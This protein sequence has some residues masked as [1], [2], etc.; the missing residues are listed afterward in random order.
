MATTSRLSDRRLLSRVAAAMIMFTAAGV[1]AHGQ[2]SRSAVVAK[3]LTQV[4]EA[5]KLE[6]IA[7][8][9]P[10]VPGTFIAALYIQGTQLLVV[11]AKYSAPLLLVD[12]IGKKDYRDVYIDLSSASVAGTK[13]F[14]QDQSCDGLVSKPDGDNLADSW[15]E[16]NKTVAFD[17]AKKAKVSEDEYLKTFNAA[18]ERY[19]KM[20]SLLVAQA[21]KPAPSPQA[22]A[23]IAGQTGRGLNEWRV[24]AESVVERA[25]T[26]A[27]S[28]GSPPGR[29]RFHGV[30][31]YAGASR[32][33]P[34][35]RHPRAR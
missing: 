13:I 32:R 11:S 2:G 19:A 28:R 4:L 31:R 16:H 22:A 27:L 35:A 1:S 3:E 10:S 6:G 5:A 15:E 33:A 20:L 25:P 7:T 34:A 17:G 23:G 8:A 9:D 24:S 14:I 30:Q 12:K 29:A 21:K 18:D 26:R